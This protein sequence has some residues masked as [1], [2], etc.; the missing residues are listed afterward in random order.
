M[1]QGIIIDEC[2]VKNS[3]T[4]GNPPK[5]PVPVMSWVKPWCGVMG[6]PASLCTKQFANQNFDAGKLAEAT[7]RKENAIH[8]NKQAFPNGREPKP[9][10]FVARNEKETRM[11]KVGYGV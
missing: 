2:V 7:R 6:R 11:D 5:L 8:P 1:E 9:R 10:L 4:Q 3:D